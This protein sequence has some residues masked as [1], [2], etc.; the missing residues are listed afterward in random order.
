MWC[1]HSI[2][3]HNY[4]HSTKIRST[5]ATPIAMNNDIMVDIYRIDVCKIH[6][7]ISPFCILPGIL[8]F[9]HLKNQQLQCIITTI[10]EICYNGVL[11]VK[12]CLFYDR[13]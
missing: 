9:E 10:T 12:V 5:S 7:I 4:I 6:S 11:Y 3:I 8:F 2:N 1:K 13:Q